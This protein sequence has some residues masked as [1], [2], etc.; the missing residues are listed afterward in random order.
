[1]AGAARVEDRDQD[2]GEHIVG[3]QDTAVREE[4]HGVADVACA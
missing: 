2:A 4:D 1:L 3:E